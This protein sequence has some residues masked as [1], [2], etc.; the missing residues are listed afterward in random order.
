MESFLNSYLNKETMRLY[1]RGI[2]KFV[3][4]YGKSIDEILAERKGDLTPIPNENLRQN[5]EQ[6]ITKSC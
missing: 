3:E 4:W 2:D 5:K 1:K 6:T